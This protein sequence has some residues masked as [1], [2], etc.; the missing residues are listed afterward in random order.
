MYF[1]CL[2]GP[3]STFSHFISTWNVLEDFTEGPRDTF[4]MKNESS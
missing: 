1:L 4:C 3:R 2:E